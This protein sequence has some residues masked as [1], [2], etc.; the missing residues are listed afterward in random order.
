[1]R[2][3][4]IVIQ[5]CKTQAAINNQFGIVVCYISILNTN[6]SILFSDERYTS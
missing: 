4:G 3:P 5:N 6:Y 2:T 1:M